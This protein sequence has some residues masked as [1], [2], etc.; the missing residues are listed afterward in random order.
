MIDNK[1]RDILHAINFPSPARSVVPAPA[2][3]PA[4]S[5]SRTRIPNDPAIANGAPE[6]LFTKPASCDCSPDSQVPPTDQCM[7]YCM[8]HGPSGY[9]QSSRRLVQ[10]NIANIPR[11]THHLPEVVEEATAAATMMRLRGSRPVVA[12]M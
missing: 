8:T 2:P 9:A 3:A 6:N 10:G 11:N 5:S 1:M 7:N 4:H 12:V